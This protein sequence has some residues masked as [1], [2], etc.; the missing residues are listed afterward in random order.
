MTQDERDTLIK[1]LKK[2]EANVTFTKSNGEVRVMRCTLKE[3]VVPA[4]KVSPSAR[5]VSPDV[6]AVWDLEKSEWR[7]FR[8]DK[9]TDVK[10]IP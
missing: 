7:S 9:I 6:L 5:K 3:D 8:Y 2:M 1:F 10:Y 4:P